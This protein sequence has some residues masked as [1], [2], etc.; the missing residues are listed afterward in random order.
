MGCTGEANAR[1]S[2]QLLDSQAW[3]ADLPLPAVM[4]LAGR[5]Q[6]NPSPWVQSLTDLGV[7]VEGG[8][9]LQGFL[10]GDRLRLSGTGGTT[11]L[12]K[13]IYGP[14][15]D[16]VQPFSPGTTLTLSGA[17]QAGEQLTVTLEANPSTGY[18]WYA[19]EREQALV[20]VVQAVNPT[21]V[22]P[23]PVSGQIAST[24][25]VITEPLSGVPQPQQL[26]F[27]A[28]EPGQAS[29]T[30]VYR[31]PW[32]PAPPG[33]SVSISAP[34]LSQL[35]DLSRPEGVGL[36]GT[37]S[38][39]LAAA[40][41]ENSPSPADQAGTSLPA[42]FD[43]RTR[44]SLPAVRDQGSCGSCWAFATAGAFESAIAIQGG[45][46]SIDL[47]EQYLVS[48]NIDS[49]SCNGGGT[50]HKYH[51]NSLPFNELQA[52]GVL[53]T[54]LPYT[55]TNGQCTGPYNHPY[56]LAGWKNITSSTNPLPADIKQA[57]FTYGPVKASVCAGTA[58]SR[59]TGGIFNTD[60][61]AACSGSTNHAI[62]LVGWDDAAGVWI[63]RNSW[64]SRWG[65]GGYMRIAWGTS[66][67]GRWT[68]YVEY[69]GPVL[70]HKAL[71]P[72]VAK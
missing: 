32:E 37:G 66:N 58:F 39:D 38:L 18:A 64:G 11:Q 57:I 13:L 61:K 69:N 19:A 53:E 43:W 54:Q 33:R 3:T 40:P 67:V 65:E 10:Q 9:S 5:Q 6:A 30:L 2:L 42:A 59:Y 1:I 34:V 55:A 48:C 4:G 25:L 52:G 31:R 45:P 24:G 63:L 29:L 47:S 28:V 15:S 23:L 20:N 22:S 68:S 7:Q 16:L 17:V 60:E 36:P 21:V 41:D 27:Q 70:N 46:A 8:V 44:S 14:L 51:Y 62:V 72:L 12:S 50:A 49:W 26:A 71:L 56:R 35:S